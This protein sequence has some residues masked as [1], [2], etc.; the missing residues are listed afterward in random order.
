MKCLHMAENIIRLRRLRGNTQ[1]ELAR[2]LGVTKASVSKW[3]TSQTYPDILLLPK[4]ASY[5]GVSVDELLGYEPQLSKEQIRAEYQLLAKAF[6]K[7]PFEDV[8]Q[9][10][11]EL[12]KEYY[13]CYP[14]L[15]QICVLWLNHCMLAET[16]E[17]GG[18]IL[19]RIAELADHILAECQDMNVCNDAIGIRSLV[20]LQF[21]EA[22][23]VIETLEER[24]DPRHFNGQGR[25][26]VRA[27]M[28]SGDMEKAEKFLQL[29]LYRN[30][31]EAIG[32]LLWM[33][34][35]CCH[36][37]DKIEKI[38]ERADGIMEVFELEKLNPNTAANYYFYT[39][40]LLCG[41]RKPK[42]AF[43]R[44]RSCVEAMKYLIRSGVVLHGDTFFDRLNQCF[45]EL[46]L[47]AEGVRDGKLV[48]DTAVQ[49]LSH[50]AFASLQ[51]EGQ[52]RQIRK[53]KRELEEMKHAYDTK[54]DK[55]L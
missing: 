11:E 2:F 19:R 27:Y 49:M 31:Q 26:L 46:D 29:D 18:E 25:I 14:F 53:W 30:I 17:R 51:E 50:P 39:A 9:R 12:V 45:A 35:N 8:M 15:L 44:L 23:E 20:Y 13:S 54:S 55:N 4:M 32:D 3:E 28:M 36:N 6:A 48:I 43:E 34:E 33:M 5:F 16:V 52:Q 1:E 24:A 7:E 40:V 21:G 42:E 22:Q 41:F 47:G 38:M 10:S 37:Q